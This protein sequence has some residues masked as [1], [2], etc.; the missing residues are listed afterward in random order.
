MKKIMIG[1]V[2]GLI[3]GTASTAIASS[4][5]VQAKF[6]KFNM[7]VNGTEVELES[8]PLVYQGTTYLPVRYILNLLGY[9]VTY[10]AETRTIIAE[11]P[12]ERF[13]A[14]VEALMRDSQEPEGEEVQGTE[15]FVVNGK[16]YYGIEQVNNTINRLQNVTIKFYRFL[17]EGGA[18]TEEARQEAERLLAEAEAELEE[19]LKIKEHFE[20]QAAE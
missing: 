16:T 17:A 19:L 8:D 7:V 18:P 14:D 15:E 12:V 2:I 13:L 3:I 20:K 10:L 9:D 6:S 4:E 5:F 11:K 1:L